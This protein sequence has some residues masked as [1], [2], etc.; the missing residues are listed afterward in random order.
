MLIKNVSI[1]QSG[2]LVPGQ[3]IRTKEGKI[4]QIGPELQKSVAMRR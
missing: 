1:L 4:E 3:D 2:H